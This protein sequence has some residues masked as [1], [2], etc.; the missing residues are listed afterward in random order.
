M[1]SP[2]IIGLDHYNCARGVQKVLQDYKNLQVRVK[3]GSKWQLVPIQR[4]APVTRSARMQ[5][6]GRMPRDEP[7]GR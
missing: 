4:G 3:V 1:L 7:H 5:Q 6:Q 2:S